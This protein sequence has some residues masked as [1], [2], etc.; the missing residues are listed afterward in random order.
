MKIAENTTGQELVF[1]HGMNVNGFTHCLCVV[2]GYSY[3]NGLNGLLLYPDNSMS[4]TLTFYR[5]WHNR[6]AIKKVTDGSVEV[7]LN[8]QLKAKDWTYPDGSRFIK[9]KAVSTSVDV[10][11]NNA[12]DSTK[13]HKNGFPWW[14]DHEL[15][16]AIPIPP[17]YS[18]S[19]GETGIHYSDVFDK[20]VLP[21]STSRIYPVLPE[22][23][24]DVD[25][26]PCSDWLKLLKEYVEVGNVLVQMNPKN[27]DNYSQWSGNNAERAFYTMTGSRS[28]FSIV[29]PW[30]TPKDHVSVG[31]PSIVDVTQEGWKATEPTMRAIRTLPFIKDTHDVESAIAYSVASLHSRFGAD[32]FDS[33]MRKLH[34]L[35]MSSLS[36]KEVTP[37]THLIKK[38]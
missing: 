2:P 28:P 22:E 17:V 1:P 24:A 35:A 10:L 5:N 3:R 8:S 27:H 21:T 30:I 25:M 16:I 18:Q 20:S 33:A 6:Q 11:V 23:N 29:R 9:S 38:A 19:L 36:Y 13:G 15:G 32:K 12:N 37:F 26:L 14:I 34:A 7:V 31:I 4:C